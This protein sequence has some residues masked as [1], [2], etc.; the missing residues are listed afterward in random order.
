MAQ[1]NVLISVW[2]EGSLL[3]YDGVGDGLVIEE[4]DLFLITILR[5]SFILITPVAQTVLGDKRYI[6]LK[7]DQFNAKKMSE[8]PE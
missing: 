4:S 6:L 8:M 1:Q 3:F 5:I 7:S 2:S